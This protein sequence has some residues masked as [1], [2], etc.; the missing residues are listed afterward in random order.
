MPLILGIGGAV[1]VVVLV[2]VLNSGGGKQA[3]A[4]PKSETP[5]AQPAPAPAPAPANTGPVPAGKA[6]AG[7]PPLKPAPALTPAM[8]QEGRG[9]LDQAKVTMNASVT[10]RTAGD[11]ETA[12]AKATETKKLLDQW[13]AK[14]QAPLDW[15]GEADFEGWAQPA[16]Y[17]AMMKM[18]EEHATL[19]KRARMGGGQ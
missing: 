6:V 14:L 8:L 7:K 2:V 10:A 19:L 9:I 12:R 5:A 18:Y 4:G 16:E 1:L 15:Q 11:N 3:N 17:G 13:T